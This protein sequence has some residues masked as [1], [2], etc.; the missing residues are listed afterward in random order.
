MEAIDPHYGSHDRQRTSTG[1]RI[2]AGGTKQEIAWRISA[3]MTEYQ[4]A[5]DTVMW[6]AAYTVWMDM[7]YALFPDL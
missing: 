5:G 6:E 4:D 1:V 2:G 3:K 7:K